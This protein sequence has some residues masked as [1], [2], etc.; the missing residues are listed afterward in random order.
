MKI[1]KFENYTID[2]DG[3][4]I[5]EEYAKLIISKFIDE[6]LNE[7]SLENIFH[8]TIKEDQLDQEQANMIKYAMIDYLKYLVEKTKGIRQIH[9]INAEDYN[10]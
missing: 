2:I 10:L 7:R 3:G 4:E 5:S 6:Q 9:E 1:K 8:E